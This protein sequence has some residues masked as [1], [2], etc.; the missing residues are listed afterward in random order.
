MAIPKLSAVQVSPQVSQKQVS[1]KQR[2]QPQLSLRVACAANS[3]SPNR[4]LPNRTL[5]NRAFI[6]NQ[7]ATY[8]FRLSNALSL[9]SSDPQRVYAYIMNAGPGLLAGDDLRVVVEVGDRAS[10]YLTDQSATKVHSKPTGELPAQMTHVLEVGNHAYLEYVPE[11][12]IFFPAAALKQ[13]TQITL[14]P[15]SRLVLSEIV[16]PGRLA[17]KEI[18]EFEQF[19]NRLEVRSSEGALHFVDTLKLLGQSN[20]FRTH[21]FLTDHPILGSFV[22]IAPKLDLD[23]FSQAVEAINTPADN[24]QIG[25]SPLPN[26][27][28]LFVRAMANKTRAIKI[29]QH[30]LLSTTRRLLQQQPLPD[31]P[32]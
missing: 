11:P 18:Y 2:S 3:H 27:N 19:E 10:L 28:G 29:F 30:H 22:V 1:Q 31:I 16:V 21:R 4:T 32:K 8:P 5:P 24:L 15:N 25:S 13:K 20:R 17:R 6:A 9:D 7:Y 26:C 14:H 12:I 23:R